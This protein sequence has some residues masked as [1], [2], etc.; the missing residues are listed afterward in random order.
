CSG[1]TPT[2]SR[3]SPQ[4]VDCKWVTESAMMYRRAIAK[5]LEELEKLEKVNSDL[6]ELVRELSSRPE[7]EAV[8]IFHR[9]R[10]SGDAFHVLHLVRTG[11][12]L[13]RKQPN[14]AGERS[15]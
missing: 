9:L 1:I 3:C 15:K 4:D 12:L 5:C 2:C 14:E 8:E 13:R 11:D 7:A 10:T 6:H